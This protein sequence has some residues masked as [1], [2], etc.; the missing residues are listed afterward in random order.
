[1]RKLFLCL[2]TVL[3]SLPARAV[4][5]PILMYHHFTETDTGAPMTTSRRTFRSHL[6]AL[7]EAGYTTV[8][9]A[10]LLTY[11]ETGE[12]LPEKP[13]LL[14]SDDGYSSVIEVALP[15]LREYG[16][17]MSVAVV[18]SR[19][20]Q[21]DGIPHFSPEEAAGCGLEL[22]SHTWALHGADGNGVLTEEGTLSP[23]FVPDAKQ[24]RTIPE[25]NQTVFVYPYGKYSRDSEAVLQALG[26]RITVT[27][28]EGIAQ[29]QKGSSLY[30]LPRIQP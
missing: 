28:E 9:F 14:T 21:A 5:V 11:T 2:L 10:D 8:S 16:M 13:V 4:P 23:M 15:I 1:M 24:M 7:Q 18:G 19:M 22:V 3:L 20:G 29:V 6:T 27:T 25:L 12:G 26:Y 17:T 30:G